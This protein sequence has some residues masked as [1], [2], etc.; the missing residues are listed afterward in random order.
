M[1]AAANS[2]TGGVRNSEMK[3]YMASAP[4]CAPPTEL[5]Y[6]R[7]L[8]ADPRLEPVR[9]KVAEPG[10][11]VDPSIGSHTTNETKKDPRKEEAGTWE[12]NQAGNASVAGRGACQ[13]AIL[14]ATGVDPL[15]VP[16]DSIGPPGAPSQVAQGPWTAVQELP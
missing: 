15:A 6:L 7:P 11:A 5:R 16:R 9:R 13:G 12:V 2:A 10:P 4:W 8:P 14:G 3:E 1:A